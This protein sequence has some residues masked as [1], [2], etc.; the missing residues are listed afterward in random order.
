MYNKLTVTIFLVLILSLGW[1]LSCTQTTG[2]STPATEVTKSYTSEINDLFK[3]NGINDGYVVL[4]KHGRVELQGIY[5]DEREVDLAF[6]LAQTVV[7]V[8]LVSPVTPENIKVK[9]WERCLERIFSGEV[10]GR[11]GPEPTVTGVSDSIPPGSVVNKYALVVGISRFK[12]GIQPLQYSSKDALD[13]Y[14][15][16]INPRGGNFR[17]EN[18]ILL[19]DE[20][21]TRVAI[22]NALDRIKNSAKEDDLVV[23][24]LSSHGTPP[25]KFGGVFIVT[26]DSEVKPRQRIW[27]TSITEDILRD[28]IQGV[29]AKRLIVLMDAC[30]SNGAYTQI[31]G[32]LPSGG[33]SLG[34]TEEEGYGRSRGYMA[35]R[36]LGAKDIVVD[37]PTSMESPQDSKLPNGWGKVLIS[38]SDAR[39]RSWESDKL[40]NSIFTYYFIQGLQTYNGTIKESFDYSEPLVERTVKEEK[41]MDID[42]HPQL[43][44]NRKDWNMS[45]SVP[46]G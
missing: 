36:L 13:F 27:E 6:S 12:N 15:Y 14:S 19:R 8:K 28:F 23:L 7:G 20:H 46:G 11:C 5:R 21:A 37:E 22:K 1:L 24:Y 35:K 38:A 30:Y 25:D 45:I 40:H 29:K 16:L 39:E 10:R 44:P 43:T 9:E 33:K 42:Q 31:A 32:F 18:V 2:V 3:Q 17:K 4:D 41:G 34:I 26:Y